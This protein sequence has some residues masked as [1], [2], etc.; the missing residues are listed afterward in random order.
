MHGEPT[1][2]SAYDGISVEA[3]RRVILVSLCD[4]VFVGA[5]WQVCLDSLQA[6][7]NVFEMNVCSYVRFYLVGSQLVYA[8]N[9]R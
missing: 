1:L 5:K 3:M 8:R 7:I 6:G 2:Q 9:R 4:G